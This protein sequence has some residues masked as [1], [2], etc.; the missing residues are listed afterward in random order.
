MD[1]R[2][3]NPTLTE[4]TLATLRQQGK[5]T[6]DNRPRNLAGNS[7]TVLTGALMERKSAVGWTLK[8]LWSF[9]GRYNGDIQYG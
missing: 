3:R 4:A 8:D 7:G 5:R 2:A 1:S 9:E 6:L